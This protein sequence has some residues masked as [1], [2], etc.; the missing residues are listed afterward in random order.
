[1]RTRREQDVVPPELT[2]AVGLIWGY[3]NVSQ[4]DKAHTLAKGCLRIWPDDNRLLL[5][6]AYAAVEL[7]EPLDD[8]MRA[9]M[10]NPA[11][12]KWAD[13]VLTRAHVHGEAA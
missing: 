6:A 8:K 10:S 7:M 9:A 4:F 1:M 13:L 3:L 12:K 5:M 11:C 2:L